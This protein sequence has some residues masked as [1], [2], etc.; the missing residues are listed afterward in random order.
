MIEAR[1][2]ASAVEHAVRRRPERG[3]DARSAVVGAGPAEPHH[4]GPRP[5]VHGREQQLADPTA[6]GGLRV[7]VDEVQA[8]GLRAL[9]V[10]RLPHAQHHR[11]HLRPVR[12]RHGHRREVAAERGV[13][14]VDEAG[15]AVGHRR[16]V[17]L[18]VG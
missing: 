3:E 13:Q 4:H 6:R 18:V 12:T 2:A 5:A 15:A 16:E 11:G 1:P 10:R 14:H 7:A 8:G 9:D 17:E